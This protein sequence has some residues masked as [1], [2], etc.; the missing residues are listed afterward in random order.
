VYLRGNDGELYSVGFPYTQLRGRFKD[1]TK[2]PG[3]RINQT[4]PAAVIL[5]G[6]KKKDKKKKKK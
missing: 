4:K 6:K 3:T 2:V 5:E 1:G